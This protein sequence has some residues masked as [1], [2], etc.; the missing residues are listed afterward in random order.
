L[1]SRK[2]CEIPYSFLPSLSKTYLRFKCVFFSVA[3]WASSETAG[4]EMAATNGPSGETAAVKRYRPTLYVLFS[5]V[6]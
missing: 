2:N 1:L 3:N 4:A 5:A 6:K